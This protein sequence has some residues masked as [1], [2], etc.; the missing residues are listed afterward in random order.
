M[1]HRSGLLR[2]N[3]AE[4][5]ILNE[6]EPAISSLEE[7]ELV[8]NVQVHLRGDHAIL[9]GHLQLHGQY[10]VQ[11]EERSSQLQRQIPVEITLP[12][13]RIAE[14]SDILIEVENFDVDVADARSLLVTGTLVLKGLRNVEPLR[15]EEPTEALP[16][17]MSFV[18]EAELP[19]EEEPMA[20]AVEA[21]ERQEPEAPL[22]AGAQQ[23]PPVNP[24]APN[25]YQPNAYQ[26]HAVQPNPGAGNP[27]PAPHALSP[28]TV[29]PPNASQPNLAPEAASNAEP[30]P[31]EIAEALDVK[32]ANDPAVVEADALDH[33][34]DANAQAPALENAEANVPPVAKP[35]LKIAFSSKKR[36]DDSAPVNLTSALGKAQASAQARST[37][38]TDHEDADAPAASKRPST[39]DALDWA[40]LL[41]GKEELPSPSY[42]LRV[43]LI[44][45]EDDLTALGTRFGVNPKELA[46]LNKLDLE[47][48]DLEAGRAVLIP[49]TRVVA[50]RKDK[51]KEES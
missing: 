20:R 23:T 9:Q 25:A 28:N 10:A 14:G 1:D 4:K 22:A 51:G 13:A 5:M 35:G 7:I 26:P 12:V 27:S 45:P 44:Q 47:G 2:F 33:E 8:P 18:D 48:A 42:K 30:V 3:I 32:P 31:A 11:G 49:R 41:G 6:R 17:E 50:S 29:T 21:E 36:E 39:G 40:R 24:Y 37:E 46:L 38:E 34:P 15:E 19:R 43:G 16:E